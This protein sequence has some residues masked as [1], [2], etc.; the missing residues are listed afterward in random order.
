ML[1]STLCC[2]ADTSHTLDTHRYAIYY[3]MIRADTQSA[4][5]YLLMRKCPT[6]FEEEEEEKYA[7]LFI[8]GE[9]I[10]RDRRCINTRKDVRN[11]TFMRIYKIGANFKERKVGMRGMQQNSLL[12]AKR[13][14]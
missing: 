11:V 5:R 7:L 10:K 12:S 6:G 3:T 8:G 4:R 2:H 13:F 1:S 9:L 14:V